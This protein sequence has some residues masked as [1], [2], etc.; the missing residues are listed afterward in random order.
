MGTPGNSSVEIV[1]Q[2]YH[3]E[4]TPSEPPL[5]VRRLAEWWQE[6][7]R[8]AAK[9]RRNLDPR[10][11]IQTFRSQAREWWELHQQPVQLPE[12]EEEKL[13]KNP[14][15]RWWKRSRLAAERDWVNLRR[16]AATKQQQR[17]G[18]DSDDEEGNERD[19]R[20]L[21]QKVTTMVQRNRLEPSFMNQYDIA[22]VLTGLN[23]LKDSF[24]PFMMS[25]QRA[26]K[27]RNLQQQG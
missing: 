27:L 1:Q 14:V 24:L 6:Q 25:E 19:R 10:E 8:S 2:I 3:L 22:V 15:G 7:R 11:R 9:S 4:E 18:A 16:I 23:D 5:I 13:K 26:R 17:D 12:G 20:N 21:E